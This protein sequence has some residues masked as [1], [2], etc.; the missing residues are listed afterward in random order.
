MR[1][2]AATW[3]VRR[4]GWRSLCLGQ[5]GAPHPGHNLN[6]WSRWRRR[7]NGSLRHDPSHK[8]GARLLPNCPSQC[9][10][11][12]VLPAGAG[13]LEVFKHVLIYTQRDQLFDARE[14]RF[15]GRL[16]R[17][18]SCR[19]LECCFGSLPRVDRSS[20]SISSHSSIS[21]S[22]VPSTQAIVR[23]FY[24]MPSEPLLSV[25]RLHDPVRWNVAHRGA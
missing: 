22:G 24:R 1:A 11:D 19:G 14:S 9:L 2:L 12:S 13:F 16:F 10:I 4:P 18:L 21:M 6:V 8:T 3:R 5:R 20:C 15:L 23:G 7:K 25:D 17:R